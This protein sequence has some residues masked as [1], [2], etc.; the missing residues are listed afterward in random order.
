MREL[1]FV[2]AIEALERAEVLDPVV[3]RVR[4]VV[5]KVIQPQALRDVLHGVPTGHPVHPIS[6]QVPVG[7]WTSVAV[8][9]LL[10]GTARASKILVALGLVGA[11]PS[12]LTGYTDWSVLHKQQMRVGI[13]H[14]AANAAAVVLYAASWVQRHRGHHTSGKLLGYLGFAIVGGAGVLGGH[15]AYRQAAGANHVEDVPHRFPVGWHALA[16]LDELPDGALTS[17]DVAGL[18]LLALRRGADV[19]V[20]SNTCS[21]L[22]AP[23]NEGELTTER[24]GG[25]SE[26]CITCPWHGSVFAVATG[27]VVHGP[28]TAPQP[29]FETRITNGMVEVMLPDAG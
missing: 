13:V 11:A 17:R 22:S 12:I 6:V 24:I 16:P 4:G 14:S 15:L 20:L 25:A 10:P 27:E 28:S 3:Q 23:L 21:H 9:D 19:D 5:M 18:P 7:A 29:R 8:L 26:A 2:K 1:R